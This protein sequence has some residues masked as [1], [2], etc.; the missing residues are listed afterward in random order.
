MTKQQRAV[1]EY[2]RDNPGMTVREASRTLCI[3]KVSAR[4]SELKRLGVHFDK[5][6]NKSREMMYTLKKPLQKREQIVE[7]KDGVAHISYKMVNA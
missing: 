3:D 4:L 6:R 7:I 1:Y 2:F 5:K